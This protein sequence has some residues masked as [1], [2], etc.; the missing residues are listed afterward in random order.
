MCRPSQW[1][2]VMR[3]VCVGRPSAPC[4]RLYGAGGMAGSEAMAK[5]GS[6]AVGTRREDTLVQKAQRWLGAALVL[7]VALSL[8]ATPAFAQS[9][10]VTMLGTWG[11]QELEAFEKVLAAFTAETGIE[12]DFTGTRDLV[13]VLTTR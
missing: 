2:R 11:G 1:H 7:A 12:V 4:G 10:R 13:A 3:F 8:A 5:R 6:R 9:G